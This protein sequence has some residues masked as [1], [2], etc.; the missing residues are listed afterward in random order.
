M[1]RL[2]ERLKEAAR[3]HLSGDGLCD[4]GPAAGGDD[5]VVN[6]LRQQLTLAIHVS[7][8][9]VHTWSMVMSVSLA[10]RPLISVNCSVQ[11]VNKRH[12]Q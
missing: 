5:S 8:I 11:S 12:L 3:S 6:N 9:S 7:S 2:N 1:V 10:D 4:V